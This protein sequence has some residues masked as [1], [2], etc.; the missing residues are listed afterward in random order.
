MEMG[1]RGFLQG[2][3]TSVAS[4]SLVV[5]ATAQDIQKFGKGEPVALG[6]AAR[7]VPYVPFNLSDPVLFNRQ[8]VPVAVVSDFRMREAMPGAP[9]TAQRLV[10]IAEQISPFTINTRTMGSLGR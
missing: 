6:S 4:T 3:V 8:G 7:D 5:Q 1:R 2:L 9:G 10:L